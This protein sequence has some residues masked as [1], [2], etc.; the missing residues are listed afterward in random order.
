MI[1]KNN[2][3][4]WI[5]QAGYA[6]QARVRNNIP[7]ILFSIPIIHKAL[8]KILPPKYSRVI[9]LVE[10][11]NNENEDCNTSPPST[12]NIY[13]QA[14]TCMPHSAYQ[15]L[16]H[17]YLQIELFQCLLTHLKTLSEDNDQFTKVQQ[18]SQQIF[19][20][21]VFLQALAS[22]SSS[23]KILNAFKSYL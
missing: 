12:N 5:L 10:L 7:P 18:K 8:A 11:L 9:Y 19:V 16:G 13:S 15:V 23:S 1:S 22:P 17:L 14:I 3:D 2:N 6:M 21:V 20:L 4:A